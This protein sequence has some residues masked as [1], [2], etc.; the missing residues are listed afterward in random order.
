MTLLLKQGD[1]SLSLVYQEPVLLSQAVQDSGFF[2]SMPCNGNGKCGKC[3]VRVQG[4]CSPITEAERALLGSL[5]GQGWRLACMTRAV[6]DCTVEI[7]AEGEASI[8]LDGYLPAFAPNPI[9]KRFGF[10]VD[11]GTT[12]VVVYAYDLQTCRL[13]GKTAFPNP[14]SAFGADVISRIQAALD[15]SAKALQDRMVQALDSAF[16]DLCQKESVLPEQVDAMVITGNT[17]MLYLL[18]GR[19]VDP[20]SHAPFQVEEYYG[21]QPA[22]ELCFPRFPQAAVYL[23]RCIAAFVGADITCSILSSDIAH[24]EGVSVMVDIGTNGE[25]AL[26]H[27]GA[28]YCCSTAAGPA[29]EGAK[30]SH[31]CPAGRGAINRVWA[32]EGKLCWETIGGA[33]AAGLCGTGLIDAVA[34][35]VKT[36]LIDET[37]LIDQACPGYERYVRL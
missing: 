15:G 26:F 17:T 5:A 10:A 12:T 32:E 30:I 24:R 21:R 31:G 22:G 27:N 37:G 2:L 16:F 8:V 36:G 4:A 25:M 7:P 28:L 29:F 13:V 14:Q 6:G 9:G 1:K 3:R 18:C 23:P 11:I 35:F 19:P 33:P 34:T 20:L